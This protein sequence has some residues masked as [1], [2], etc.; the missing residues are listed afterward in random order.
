MTTTPS[1]FDVLCDT[2]ALIYH[3]SR[4][5]RHLVHQ[6]LLNPQPWRF[7]VSLPTN[8]DDAWYEIA[9]TGQ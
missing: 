5:V 4:N 8:R 1:E 7:V 3:E 2:L 9:V 6:K